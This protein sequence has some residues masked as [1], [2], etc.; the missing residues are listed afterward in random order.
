[1]PA[2]RRRQLSQHLLLHPPT[3]A[4]HQLEHHQRVGGGRVVVTPV[5][6][7][8]LAVPLQSQ[9]GIAEV[10]AAVALLHKELLA[11]GLMTQEVM[12]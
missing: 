8:D 2:F 4:H 6:P 7:H 5:G 11:L 3:V 10:V 1:M 9:E 12:M